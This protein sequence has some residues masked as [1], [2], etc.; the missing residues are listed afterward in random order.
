[1]SSGLTNLYVEKLG[2]YI[3]GRIFLGV[4]PCDALPS[5]NKLKTFSIIFNLSKHDEE[6]T[7]FVSFVFKNN[8]LFYFDSLGAK[9]SNINLVKF[10]KKISPKRFIQLDTR[11]Q[12][13][14]SNF[15]GFFCL[16]FIAAFKNNIS[17]K[18]FFNIFSKN[19]KLNDDIVIRFLTKIIKKSKFIRQ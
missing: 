3:C 17:L 14:T 2:K 4:Y 11:I 19:L 9:L 15:C 6:G 1:M 8:T 7:H 13:N 12:D 10:V 16:S 5:I 18:N